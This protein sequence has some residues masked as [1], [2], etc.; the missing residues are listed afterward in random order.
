MIC[1]E[2]C[3]NCKFPDC[4]F[5]K[6]KG[7]QYYQKNKEKIAEYQRRYYQ[8]NKEKKVEYQRQYYQ[9]KKSQSLAI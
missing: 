8:E 1:D 6:E 4:V 9:R 7:R 5:D 2:D 3:F